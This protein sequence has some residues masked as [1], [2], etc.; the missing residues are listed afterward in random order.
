MEARRLPRIAILLATYNGEQ[1]LDEQLDTI[2]AQEGVA[3]TVFASDDFSTDATRELLD[4]RAAT[5][6][7]I[8]LTHTQR[9]CGYAASNFFHL[10][11]SVPTS[12]FDFYAFADQ[13]D[14]WL[15]GRLKRQ[16]DILKTGTAVAISSN[17]IA[18]WPDGR[19]SVV[20]KALPQ[21][22]YDY[23]FESPGPGCSFLLSPSA[24]A[25]VRGELIVPDS[26]A[27][28]ARYHDWLIYA[29]VRGCDMP[30]FI[31][32]EAA[33]LYRQHSSNEVGANH[34]LKAAWR[35]LRRITQGSFHGEVIDV[36]EAVNDA[37][38]RRNLPP[39]P[40]IGCGMVLSE[41]RR[42]TSHRLSFA[43]L[44]LRG[45]SSSR[46]SFGRRQP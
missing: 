39:L 16:V 24:Y 18:F 44:F 31:D 22:K 41:G 43:L 20:E 34:G 23:L 32:S 40:R 8:V 19:R 1:W 27:R 5:D 45:L 42:K 10:I 26:V 11:E 36:F 28:R 4:R 35:R 13:D 30:W 2:L 14:I 9:R 12:E 37:R 21:R 29:L 25:L 46:S 33:L 17:V 7:R 15:D 6:A 38:R 3:I